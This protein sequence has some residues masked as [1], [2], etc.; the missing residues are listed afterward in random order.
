MRNLQCATDVFIVSLPS[1]ALDI[2]SCEVM[3][4]VIVVCR[5]DLSSKFIT[6]K[7][8]Q[9]QII[10]RTAYIQK[11]HIYKTEKKTEYLAEY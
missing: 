1:A 3:L 10:Y 8:I 6:T 7:Y 9:N 2:V 4:A 11:L 5:W